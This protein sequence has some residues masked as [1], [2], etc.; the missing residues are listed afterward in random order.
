M[1]L[2]HG[3]QR[4]TKEKAIVV[5]GALGEIF[6]LS[7]K[8]RKTL[9]TSPEAQEFISLLQNLKAEAFVC[10][11]FIIITVGITDILANA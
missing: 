8:T 3:F 2:N 11:E 9:E 7:S 4:Q 10:F 5:Q 6:L 1:G